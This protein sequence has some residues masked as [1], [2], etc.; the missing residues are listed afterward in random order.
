MVI[1][2]RQDVT[3]IYL[4]KKGK[5]LYYYSNF[6]LGPNFGIVMGIFFIFV[7]KIEKFTNNLKAKSASILIILLPNS[8]K[9]S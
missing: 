7:C 2:V 6:W 9:N 8:P 4:K 1:R 3:K 5:T